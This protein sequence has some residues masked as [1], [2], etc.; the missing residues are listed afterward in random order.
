MI[1]KVKKVAIIGIGYWG[2]K[3]KNSIIKNKKFKLSYIADINKKN[4]I[5]NDKIPNYT[6]LVLDYKQID[7]KKIDAVFIVTPAISHF[8]IS[9]FFL[10]KK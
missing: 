10:E 6:K 8:K 1:K 7:H 9:K 5:L 3:I 4:L 2:K